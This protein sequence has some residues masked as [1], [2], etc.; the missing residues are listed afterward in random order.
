[1]DFFLKM[2]TKTV[3]FSLYWRPIMCRDFE[4]SYLHSNG[5]SADSLTE[6]VFVFVFAGHPVQELVDRLHNL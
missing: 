2:S 3:D 1:M 6:L 4:F 5:R